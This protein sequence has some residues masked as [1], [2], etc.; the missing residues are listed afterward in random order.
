[1][2]SRFKGQ[3]RQ[4]AEWLAHVLER[5]GVT[6][7]QLT[8][9]GLLL[10][11]I[12]AGILATGHL[13][14]GGAL[15][16]LAGAFDMLDGALARVANRAT[17]FGAFLDSTVD[18]FAE[19]AILLGLLVEASQRRDQIVP[20]LAFIVIVGSLMV[21]YTRAR[22][23]G[24]GLNNEIGIAPRPE[25]V[26][27]LGAGLILGL[28]VPALVLL[29]ALTYVTAIQRVIHVQHLT[30]EPTPGQ[31]DPRPPAR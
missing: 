31:A 18:R 12:V 2:F 14:V 10:N 17:T 4:I 9:I 7:S 15:V 8:M 26:V 22:A 6:P 20:P 3:A 27:I 28:E 1:V 13:R 24:L 19:A 30:R 29:A 23:E 21:S 5:T 16:L 25:R 11:L